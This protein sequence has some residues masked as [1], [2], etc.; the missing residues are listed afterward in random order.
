M[1]TIAYTVGTPQKLGLK[2]REQRKR[3]KKGVMASLMLTPMVD[4]FSLLVI[5]LL[6]FFNASP[7]LQL[8]NGMVLPPSQSSAELGDAPVVSVTAYEVLVNHKSIGTVDDIIKN[9]EPFAVAL[10]QL[11]A[12]WIQTHPSETFSGKINFEAHEDLP[13]TQVSQLMAV[14]STHQYGS[15][16]LMTL[17]N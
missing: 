14:L 5:F 11:R 8:T 16:E 17:G 3:Q 7:D 13:S 4:M 9:P 10:D 2:A 6:Q 1:S 15:M 12:D